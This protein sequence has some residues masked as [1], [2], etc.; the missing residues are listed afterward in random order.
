M[1]PVPPAWTLETGL[2]SETRILGL[3]DTLILVISGTCVD[4]GC[5]S[6]PHYELGEPVSIPGCYIST[7][8]F[9]DRLDGSGHGLRLMAGLT[10]RDSRD[11]GACLYH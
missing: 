6:L 9:V 11:L 4:S 2:P 1:F 3:W 7:Y 10:G 8:Y 5:S